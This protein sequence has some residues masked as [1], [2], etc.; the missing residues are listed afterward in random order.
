MIMAEKSFEQLVDQI[1]KLTVVELADFVKALEERFGVVAGM[2]MVASAAGGAQEEV[3]AEEKSEY[4]VTLKDVGSEK[5]KVIKALRQVT[6]MTL[7]DAKKAFE[8]APT[9]L[10]EAASKEKA[11][12]M[13]KALE[14]AGATVELT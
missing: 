14:A 1:S 11:E 4:K 2:P 3:K 9:V 12:E 10:D 8:E 7:A 6:T 5:I 13:K